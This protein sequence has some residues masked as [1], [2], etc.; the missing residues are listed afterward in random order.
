MGEAAREKQG[1][2]RI[3]SPEELHD[4]IHVTGPRLWVMLGMIIFLLAGLIVFASTQRIESTVTI[5]AETVGQDADGRAYTLTGEMT[6]ERMNQ[7]KVGMEARVAGKTGTVRTIVE[8]K[9]SVFVAV[10]LNPGETGLQAGAYD[11]EIVL[12]SVRPVD[13]LLKK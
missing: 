2:R 8:D 7:A 1:E 3:S 10:E 5:R 13:Y 12:E 11:A 9:E 6:G 4:Y